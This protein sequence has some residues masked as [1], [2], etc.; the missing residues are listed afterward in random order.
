VTNAISPTA[1]LKKNIVAEASC[2][3]GTSFLALLVIPVTIHKVGVE[4]YGVWEILATIAQIGC[5]CQLPI[6]GTMLWSLS[7]TQG[8]GDTAGMNRRFGIGLTANLLQCLLVLTVFTV[9]GHLFASAFQVPANAFRLMIYVVGATLVGGFS[10]TLAAAI[11]GAQR[12]ALNSVM[13]SV[14]LVVQYSVSIVLV[15]SG[16]GLKGLAAGLVCNTL[17]TLVGSATIAHRVVPGLRVALLWPTKAEVHEL[18]GYAASMMVGSISSTLRGQLDRLVLAHFASPS[19]VG[20]YGIANRLCNLIFEFNK[21]IYMPIIPAAAALHAQNN[22]PGLNRVFARFM[23]VT[24]IVTGTVTV[25]VAGLNERFLMVWIGNAPW[26]VQL[27]LALLISSGFLQ[28]VL[29]GPGSAICRG[30]G[31]AGIETLY[32]SVSLVI[33]LVLTIVLVATVGFI[34]TVIASA[35]ATTVASIFFHRKTEL[36]L[37][38]TWRAVRNIMVVA[39][40]IATL[41]FVSGLLPLPPGRLH[42]ILWLAPLTLFGV[43]MYLILFMVCKAGDPIS[44]API[45]SRSQRLTKL[46][47]ARVR[48]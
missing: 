29:T 15:L 32:L 12:M 43:A 37:S 35:V 40:T 21:Y 14:G 28:L 20:Y 13:R 33:N 39:L 6:T 17:L 36:P 46:V 25:V 22:Q 19:W 9:I 41:H 31:R 47:S 45:R 16:F 5:I 34:G 23:T 8:H 11:S 2:R 42:E 27:L 4:W 3:I 1:R 18:W 7:R 44:L 48:G 30:I 26:Q 38:E 24:G 10:E